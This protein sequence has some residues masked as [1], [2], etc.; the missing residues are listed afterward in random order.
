MISPRRFFRRWAVL[1]PAL[2]LTGVAVAQTSFSGG[3]ITLTSSTSTSVSSAATVSGLSGTVTS[4]TL[5]LNSLTWANPNSV[6]VLLVA[7]G[8]TESLDVLS[9]SCNSTA[10]SLALADSASNILPGGVGATCTAGPYKATDYFPGA[11]SFPGGPSSYSSAGDGTDGGYSG[12]VSGTATFSNTFISNLTTSQ[13]NGTWTLYVASQVSSPAAS[14]AIGSWTITFTTAASSVST[15]TSLS[16]SPNPSFTTSPNA[17]V[18]LTATVS[19]SG[20]P[21]DNG[22]VS[23]YDSVE[24]TLATGVSVNASGVATATAT[25]SE[26]GEHNLHAVYNGGTGFDPS[27]SSTVTQIANNHA[28]LVGGNSLCNQGAITIPAGNA[29]TG[30]GGAPYPSN[31]VLGGTEETLSG[32]IQKV[33]LSLNGFSDP[34]PNALGF[35]LVAPDGTAYEFM[36]MTGGSSAT[37]SINLV[38][39]DAAATSMS[40]SAT[41]TAGTYKPTSDTNQTTTPD[42]YP[43]PAPSTFAVAAPAGAA[44]LQQEFGGKGLAGTWKL[45]VSNRDPGASGTIANGWCMNLTMQSGAHGTQTVVTGSPNPAASGATVTLTATVTV[46]DLSGLTVN[47]GTV[48]FTDG[49][50]TLGTASLVSGVATL[51]T[52][53]LAEGTHHIIASYGGSN[54]PDVFGVSSGNF[55][56]RIDHAT[57]PSGSYIYCNSGAIAVPNDSAVTGTAGPYPSNITV[58]HLPGTVKALAVMLK[59][60]TASQINGLTSLLVGPGGANIDFFSRVGGSS[61]ISSPIDLMFYDTAGA[62]IPATLTTGGNYKP[63]SATTGN[64]YPACPANATGCQSPP[65]GPPLSSDPFS[66]ASYA[67]PASAAIFGNSGAAGVFGGTTSSSFNGNGEWSL[68]LNQVVNLASNVNIAG[69][70]CLD[71]IENVPVLSITKGHT[72]NFTQGQSGVQFT[73]AVTNQGPGPTGGTVTVTDT[74]PSGLTPTGAGTG[75]DASWSCSAVGQTVTCTNSTDVSSGN[76]F[77]TLTLAANVDNNATVGTNSLSNVASVSGGG[78]SGSVN[79]SADSITIVAAPD[80]TISKTHSGTLTAGQT[81][82]YQITVTNSA[83]GSTTSGQVTVADTPPSGFTYNAGS[84]TLNGWSCGFGSGQVTCTITQAVAGGSSYPQIDLAFDIGASTSG[85]ATN[86]A[87]VSGGG[88]V[89]TANDSASDMGTVIQLPDLTVTKSHTGNFFQNETG[90]TYT[91]TVTNSGMGATTGAT[92]TVTD[93]LPSGLTATV[94]AGTGW[95][96]VLGTLTCTRSDVLAGS[97]SYAAITLTVDVAANAAASVTN[98]VAVSG[99]GETNTTNDTASDVTTVTPGSDLTLAKAHSGSF[100]QGDTG[101]TYTLTVTNGGGSPTSGT[102]TVTDSLPIGLTATAISGTGWSCTLGTLTCTRSDALAASG[103]YPAI[104]VTVNVANNAATSVTNTA[105]VSG[106]NEV[107]TGNDGASDVTA[108]AEASDMTVASSHAGN[109]FQ[110]Q[111]G[112]AYT[113]TVSNAGP[114]STLGTVT[115]VDTLPSGLTGTAI[116]G[117]GWSCTLGTLTCTRSDVLPASGS[118]PGIT[119]TV[120]VAPNASASLTN[121]ASVSGGGELNTANNS[122]SDPTI[123]SPGPDLTIIKGHGGTFRQGDTGDVY[124]ITVSNGGGS[125]TVGTVSVVDTLPTGLTATVIAGT[126][127]S[128]TLGTL[129]CTRTDALAASSSYPPVTVT[130]NVAA[131]ASASVTNAAAVSGG[132]DVNL[133][134]NSASDITSVTQVADLTIAKAHTASFRQGDTADSYTI[135]VGNAGAGPTTGSVTVTDVLP[136]GLTATAIGGTGWGCTLGTLTCTRTDALGASASYPAIGIT[137]SVAPNAPA[138]VTNMATVSGGGELNTANDSASDVTAIVAVADLTIAKSHAGTFTQGDT[139][140]TY[141]LTVGNAGVGP[142][143][144]GVTVTDTLPA[145]LTGTAI[146]GTGWSCTLA[147]LSCSRGDIL[148]ASG[149]YPPITVTVN[150]ASNAAASVTNTASVAG[151][152]ELATGNNTATDVTTIVQVPDLTI[153]KSHTGQFTGGGTGVYRL[154]VSNVGSNATNAAVTV[155]DLLP[156]GLTPTAM[157]GDGWS[158]TVGTLTCTRDDA[159]AQGASYPVISLSVAVSAT[160]ASSVTNTAVV[161]GGGERN[162]ANDTATDVTSVGCVYSLTPSSSAIPASG[163]A[164]SFSI[165][166]GAGCPVTAATDSPWITVSVSGTTVN[167]TVAAN[168]DPQPRRG[169]ITVFDQTFIVAQA[170]AAAGLQVS[171]DRL[172]FSSRVNSPAPPQQVE[173]SGGSGAFTATPSDSW[174]AVAKSS[175]QLPATITISVSDAGLSAGVHVGSVTVTAGS[176]SQTVLVN[177]VV[178]G[179]PSLV[180]NQTRLNFDYVIGQAP[181]GPQSL[182][183]YA[184]DSVAI[185][186]ATSASW[187]TVTPSTATA[188][189]TLTVSVNPSNLPSLAPGTY[190]DSVTITSTSVTNSPLVV[191]ITLVVASQAPHFD[192]ANIVNAAS[193]APGPIAPGGLFT[194]LASSLATMTATAPASNFPFELGGV[195]MTIDGIPVPLQ[196]V[197]PTQINAEAPFSVTVG[198]HTLVLTVNGVASDPVQITVAPSAPGLFLVNGRAAVLNQDYSVNT[199]ANPAAAGSVIMAYFTGQGAVQHI[200]SDPLSYTV[201]PTTASIGGQSATVVFSG[202]APGFIGLAQANITVPNLAPGD[203]NLVITVG[204]VTSNPA[205]VAVH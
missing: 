149:T 180:P 65:V 90:A 59:Q 202:L 49:S 38:L 103:S 6:A 151:G 60:L 118:Y 55:N 129:T 13:M 14:G 84:S 164:G 82:T 83:T 24:G 25:L 183:I 78:S 147:T 201:A 28:A 91:I 93:T 199:A 43:S 189:G 2:V 134:N 34:D 135:T 11:D 10:S 160:A 71:F 39:D 33:T 171:P 205:S 116:A 143:V 37:G 166:T 113:L 15:T 46:T 172:N 162:T 174:I 58:T 192:A 187:A 35:Q 193:F 122:A 64:T 111:N 188:P 69:G 115:V 198:Q 68:Y 173:V 156:A 145:G 179:P 138:S 8:A 72:G 175:S 196:Y 36:S 167:Y 96:C 86:S 177:Y 182:Q 119:L 142:T 45:Y 76:S 87:T 32:I 77:P 123:V 99:G 70:W 52:N 94:I 95:S 30:V 50:T 51:T 61:S 161:S 163:T 80:L 5:T 181:P 20:G 137:V 125:P 21:A 130:V 190:Q 97:Q 27:T 88:E 117:T 148:N 106:G 197:S 79:S 63:T 56:L 204:G 133:T 150:V 98:N 107:N 17:L 29:T 131:N 105:T 81:A 110:G 158:C 176:L 184:T 195:S 7:P 140:D 152:G 144:G 132:G 53:S 67:Q 1:C 42:A 100:R 153:A 18:T 127:W 47:A 165:V 191:P 26:E 126:G 3:S 141:T 44:T 48:T 12:R 62:G 168:G 169:L 155:T 73:V 9:G 114:G 41:L 57:V 75:T 154:T 178:N 112:A 85:S 23:F 92:V 170:A 31:L 194:I 89:N 54:S 124:S 157:T 19:S 40:R 66:P 159:L 22:T 136:T 121:S 16:T 102:V 203:Y 185:S 120:N 186:A 4:I 109:F 101:D 146:A 74:M 200:G 104:T 128:C 108:I 139:G